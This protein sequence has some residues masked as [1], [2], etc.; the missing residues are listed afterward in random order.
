[1][2]GT[3]E[4]TGGPFAH[5]FVQVGRLVVAGIVGSLG[6]GLSGCGGPASSTSSSTLRPTPSSPTSTTPTPVATPTDDPLNAQIIEAY[7][8]E[9][10]AFL[11]A[12][13]DPG[14]NPDDPLIAQTMTGNER[15]NVTLALIKDKQQGLV[16]RGDI[17]VGSPHV[18]SQA[19]DVATLR[20]CDYAT[21][22]K[23]SIA[24]GQRVPA[25]QARLYGLGYLFTDLISGQ[26]LALHADVTLAPYQV[27][28]LT[29]A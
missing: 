3:R 17:V 16:G 24:T 5:A 1:M 26:A 9:V 18:V 10:R 21:S 11:H 28:W 14:P 20:D 29:A 25:N 15:A 27:L 12:S 13:G 19:A 4:A 6:I 23:Y 7:K 22:F 8:A 2:S